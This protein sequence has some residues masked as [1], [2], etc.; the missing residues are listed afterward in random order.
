MTEL[1]RWYRQNR[2]KMNPF[3]IAVLIHTKFVT[4]HSFVDGNGRV[5]RALMN[6]VLESNGYP[7]LYLGLEQRDAYLDA[8]AQGNY[9]NRENHAPLVD[10]LYDIY[11]EQHS[12]VLGDMPDKVQ[13]GEV[14]A[15]PGV[16]KL[17]GEFVKLK[18]GY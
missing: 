14:W 11:V 6:F 10:L 5:A 18:G 8:V 12:R 16:E 2:S 7:A 1:V 4:I 17:A 15:F 3:E 13:K 9:E